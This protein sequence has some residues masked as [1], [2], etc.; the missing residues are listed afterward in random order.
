VRY[1]ISNAAYEV[2][3]IDRTLL[4]DLVRVTGERETDLFH[5]F[6]EEHV[7]APLDRDRPDY[8]GVSILNAQQIIP[9]LTLARRLRERGHTVLIGGTVYAKFVKELLARPE[10]FALFCNGIVP[11]EGESAFGALAAGARIDGPVS[12]AA[13]RRGNEHD[14]R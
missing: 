3:G 5:T 1:D 4:K 13:F 9:G 14:R 2:D 10:F 7:L 12:G 11:Y 8:V 6:W